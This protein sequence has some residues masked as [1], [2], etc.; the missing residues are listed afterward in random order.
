MAG[1]A[2]ATLEFWGKLVGGHSRGNEIYIKLLEF[3]QTNQTWDRI[4]VLHVMHPKYTTTTR[5]YQG[6]N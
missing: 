4:W 1:D 3:Y 6:V 5:M 2:T